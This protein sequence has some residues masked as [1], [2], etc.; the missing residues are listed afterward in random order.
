MVLQVLKVKE[1]CSFEKVGR[2]KSIDVEIERKYRK[3]FFESKYH[4]LFEEV[5]EQSEKGS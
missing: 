3:S 4:P 1:M 2:E 5:S